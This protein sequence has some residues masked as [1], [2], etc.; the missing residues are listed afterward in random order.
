MLGFKYDI[1]KTISFS[2]DYYAN[3]RS[4]DFIIVPTNACIKAMEEFDLVFRLENGYGLLFQKKEK[5]GGVY[6]PSVPIIS[7]IKLVF[8]VYCTVPNIL[9]ITDLEGLATVYLSNRKNDGSLQNRLTQLSQL[10]VADKLPAPGA[11]RQSLSFEA[12]TYKKIT[13]RR[14]ESYQIT[15]FPIQPGQQTVELQFPKDGIYT[16]LKEGTNGVVVQ[17]DRYISDE[18]AAAKP[19]WGVLE[20]FLD[21]NNTGAEEFVVSLKER[22][23]A[24]IYFFIDIKEKQFDYG[25]PDDLL[26]KYQATPSSPAD[27]TMFS[28]INPEADSELDQFVQLIQHS[29]P[30]RIQQVF[31]FQSVSPLNIRA[32]EQQ[33]VS[34]HKSLNATPLVKKLPLPVLDEQRYI[35]VDNQLYTTIFFNI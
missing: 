32:K 8:L 1:I 9:N 11:S 26:I 30:E 22:I 12:D 5:N 7:R 15:Q 14:I 17:E 33:T 29:D 16:I 25:T 27:A 3:Q 18:V 4:R 19:V 34:L 31:V 6:E 13:L 2:H 21:A 24:W 20:L 23:N 28:R 10:T 35:R